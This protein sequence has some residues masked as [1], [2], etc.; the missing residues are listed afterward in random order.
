MERRRGTV[1]RV[2]EE[3]PGLV[4]VEVEVGGQTRRAVNYP[5][6]TGP[7]KPGDQVVLNTTATTLELGSGGV[8]FITYVEGQDQAEL[9]GAGHI[10]KLRYTP[11]QIRC[12]SVE[13]EASPYHQVLAEAQDL[14]GIPVVIISVHSMLV[15]VL[16]GLRH[17]ATRPW[18]V[19]YLMT[20]GGALPLPWSKTVDFLKREGYLVSTITVGHAF[21]GDLEAVNKYSGLL[22]AKYAA[23]AEV[24][25]AGMGPGIVG[26]GTLFGH[27][28]VEQGELVNAV[29]ILGGRAIVV[30]RLSFADQRQRHQGVSHHFLI[31]LGKI[32]LQPAVIS[33]PYLDSVNQA[34]VWEQMERAGV[35]GKH[36]VRMV[37]ASFIGK[38]LAVFPWQVTYMGRTYQEDPYFF[39]AAAAAGVVAAEMLEGEWRDG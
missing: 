36:R 9:A 31:A 26:T 2:L 24:V 22:A 5:A 37:D 11:W 30:P 16:L 21:G 3:R 12:L 25:I 19:A 15:P 17:R 13:E 38:E 18:R 34:R 14:Q 28:G 33:L 10:M 32:A 6:L 7:V 27:T 8:D 20:D 29:A 39:Q 35:V 23:G 4:E 1:R